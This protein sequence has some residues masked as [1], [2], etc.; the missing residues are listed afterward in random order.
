MTSDF[1]MRSPKLVSITSSSAVESCPSPFSSIIRKALILLARMCQL[2]IREQRSQSGSVQIPRR[3]SLLTPNKLRKIVEV[4]ARVRG[5]SFFFL[6]H[7][8]QLLLCRIV[9]EVMRGL[10]VIQEEIVGVGQVIG[11][12]VG[13]AGEKL[14]RSPQAAAC[15]S[16]SQIPGAS[17]QRN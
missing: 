10:V 5:A 8:S 14:R 7:V 6:A 4:E 17:P 9:S 3:C 1:D 16:S 12:R 13:A 11:P 15:G 2:V